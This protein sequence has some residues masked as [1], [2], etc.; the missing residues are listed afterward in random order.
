MKKTK[1]YCVLVIKSIYLHHP[2]VN[3]KKNVNGKEK[4]H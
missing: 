3:K 2:L 1:L 4:K